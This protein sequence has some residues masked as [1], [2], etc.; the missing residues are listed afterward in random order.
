MC[1]LCDNASYE[2]TRHMIM[3]CQFHQ[4]SRERMLGMISEIAN[5]DGADILSVLIG[6]YIDGWSFIDMLPV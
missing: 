4:D 2:D 3:Q 1:I 5:I 6:N